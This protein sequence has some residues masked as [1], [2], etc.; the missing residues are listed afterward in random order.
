M[1]RLTGAL[2]LMLACWAFA[3]APA[4][5]QAT[6]VAVKRP[7]FGGACQDCPWGAMAEI[8]Q[9]AMKPYGFD[10]QVCYTCSGMDAPR[11]VA[12]A[13]KGPPA[14][15]RSR[16]PIQPPDG[17]VDFGAT[18]VFFLWEAYQ[19]AGRYSSDR[20]M[21]QLRLIATIQDPSWLVVAV[22]K[23]SG[24][25]DLKQI[26]EKK[27]PVRVIGNLEAAYSDA[28]LEYYG[29]TA[30]DLKSWG[31]SVLGREAEAGTRLDADVI[32]F[33]ASR[34][35]PPEF[36]LL[37]EISQTAELAYLGLPDDLVASMAKRFD[38][39]RRDIPVGFLRGVER[40]IP[41]VARSGTAVYTRADVPESFTY[42]V[43]KALDEQQGLF[44]WSNN[45]FSYNRYTVAK[46]LG[47]PLHPGAER[48]YRERGYLPK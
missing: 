34:G 27:L 21:N 43:A 2:V 11:I 41:T 39:E 13:K 16:T 8:V 37:H 29:I 28:V 30:K 10:V 35:L 31:G 6:G 45:T 20:P 17:P 33:E 1:K 42:T 36:S 15:A 48:Y 24:I 23:S 47:V 18:H 40:R 46:A 26:R 22:K 14:T 7:V 4:A 19:G 9:E 44:A 3:A 5:A 38:L 32:I 12:G 25:T